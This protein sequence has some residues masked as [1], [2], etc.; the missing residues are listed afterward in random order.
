M[1]E[2]VTGVQTCALPICNASISAFPLRNA[3]TPC[4][5]AVSRLAPSTRFASLT[6]AFASKS[7]EPASQFASSSWLG[8]S[9]LSDR[10]AMSDIASCSA[11]SEE[12]TSELQSLMRISYAVFCLKKKTQKT[13]K[14]ITI[15]FLVL[16]DKA[17]DQSQ[18]LAPI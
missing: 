13:N 9:T 6:V 10:L 5:T 14:Y 3:S 8:V 18:A 1:C 16:V 4:A 2:L 7:G 12:H 15:N 11:R 17:S